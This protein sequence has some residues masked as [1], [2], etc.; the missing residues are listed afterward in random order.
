[1]WDIDKLIPYA[2]NARRISDKAVDK[3]A[4]SIKEFGFRQPIVVDAESVIVVGHTR[5][6]AAKKLEMVKVPVNVITNITPEQIEAYRIADNRTGEESLCDDELLSLE[7]QELADD[8]WLTAL[9]GFDEKEIA[10]L[11]SD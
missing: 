7:F 5:L 6:L 11:L 10:D 9:T 3:V 2:R 8:A 1:M 4:G